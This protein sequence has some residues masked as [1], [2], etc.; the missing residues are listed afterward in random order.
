MNGSDPPLTDTIDS[1]R[2]E[3]NLAQKLDEQQRE[4]FM[5]HDAYHKASEAYNQRLELVRAER[6]R[7]NW[8][9]KLDA[10]YNALHDA[11]AA[12]LRADETFYQALRAAHD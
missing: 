10:E 9:M 5:A 12:A 2:R 11:Q 7:G 8:S 6:G 1:L 4:W 3:R